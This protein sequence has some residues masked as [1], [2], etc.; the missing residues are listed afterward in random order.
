MLQAMSEIVQVALGDRSYDVSIGAFSADAIADKLAAALDPK[1]TG[2]AVLIDAQV[3]ERSARG[4]R[5][6]R[7]AGRRGCPASSGWS[8]GRARR[9]RT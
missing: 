8:C 2:V 9:A 5:A 4:A 1:T 7:G 6:G 3:A